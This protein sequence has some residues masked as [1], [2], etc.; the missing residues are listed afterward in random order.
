MATHHQLRV[1]VATH[2]GQGLRSSDYCWAVEGEL[3]LFGMECATDLSDID[4]GCGCRRGMAG[5]S[6][7]KATTTFRVACVDM[8]HEEYRDAIRSS[9]ERGGWIA[10]GEDSSEPEAEALVEDMVQ[11]LL[12]TARE[13]PVGAILEKRG[14]L[15]RIRR[16]TS[17]G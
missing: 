4:G 15:V 10:V 5:A 17:T 12:A 6:S 13:F 1:L 11:E 14:H 2:V 9:L 3:V 8:T 7:S 16:L